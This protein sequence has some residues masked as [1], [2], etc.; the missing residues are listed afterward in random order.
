M[1]KLVILIS[2]I[3]FALVAHAQRSF[4]FDVLQYPNDLDDYFD[5]SGSSKAKDAVAEF[6]SYYNSGKFTNN[7]KIQVIRLTNQM[8]SYNYQ[9]SPHFENYFNA[10]NG[11]V[12]NGLVSKFDNWHKATEKAFNQGKDECYNFLQISRNVLY[13]KVLLQTTG[14]NWTTTNLDV[15]FTSK[16]TP[17]FIFKNTDLYGITP[18]DTL[19]I[20]RTSGTYDA[21]K[22]MWYGRGGRTD[23]TRVGLDSAKLIVLLPH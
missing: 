23:F 10:I 4:S 5:A 20:Y 14:I 7:Q 11:L 17:L 1:K 3:S 12:V 22:D 2:I 21:A 19:E 13:D 16:T 18:G 15:D 6:I 8:L 9:P